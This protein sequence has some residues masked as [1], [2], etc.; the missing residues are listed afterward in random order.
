MKIFFSCLGKIVFF[1]ALFA[2]V[3]RDQGFQLCYEGVD[4]EISAGVAPT[5][6]ID[7]DDF[8][9]VSCN[10]STLALVASPYVPLFK[11][12]GFN[13]LF[14]VP[15]YLGLHVGYALC[16]DQ[17]IYAEL[18]YRQSK[19]RT[20][21]LS[22]LVIPNI[23]T[24]SFAMTPKNN[25]RIVDAYIGLR[26]YCQ[27]SWCDDI[28]LF[29]GGKIGLVHHAKTNFIFSTASLTIPPPTPFISSTLPLFLS[30]TV[31]AIGAN[32]G[33]TYEVGC[34]FSCVITAEFILSCGPRANPNIPFDF[35]LQ[36]IFINPIL[37]PNSFI[38]GQIGTE[39]AV[40]L[41]I[42]FKYQF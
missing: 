42:G 18:N 14:T 21:T 32:I 31:P 6:W 33:L 22:S 38:I 37:A 9:A 27:S 35:L 36:S 10:A 16:E 2:V 30:N 41:T 17:E 19:S 11:M 4:V 7:R 29:L 34:D 23:D 39:I 12:P 5:F 20:Y 13:K 15:W 3:T 28:A 8:C 1:G 26:S 24:I 40:P 25:Y